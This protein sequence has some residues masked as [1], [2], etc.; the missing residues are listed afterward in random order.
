[1]EVET[2]LLNQLIKHKTSID[3][4]IVEVVGEGNV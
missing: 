1:V 4:K 2:D 3:E